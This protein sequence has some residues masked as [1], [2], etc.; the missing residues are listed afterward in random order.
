MRYFLA[1]DIPSENRL[2][3]KSIQ[4]RLHTLI[5]QARLIDLDKLHFTLAFIENQP[6]EL[7]EVLINIMKKAAE[8]VKTFEVTP[9]YID[10]FPN[11]H[12]PQVIWV[13]VKGDVDKVLQVR[14]RV[15]DGL[16][17]IGL[18][19]DPRRFIPH[20]TIAKLNN[21]IEIT[22]DME[23]ELEKIMTLPFDLIQITSIKLFESIPQNGFHSHNTLAEIKLE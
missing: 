5:P 10:G 19:A 13:G 21:N 18:G 20:I 22:R 16:T 15:K 4:D 9:A 6:S 1:F 7:K 12:N 23:V 14:E 2:Q 8:N 17:D 11:I 3:F